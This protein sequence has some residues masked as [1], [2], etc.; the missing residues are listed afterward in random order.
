VSR[1]FLRATTELNC[2]N[3]AITLI[4]PICLVRWRA[5]HGWCPK[6]IPFTRVKTEETERSESE[7]C[8]LARSYPFTQLRQSC[9]G[10]AGDIHGV[11]D[12]PTTSQNKPQKAPR[13]SEKEVCGDSGIPR[14]R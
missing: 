13:V 6:G 5:H 9:S 11:G 4:D 1:E 12:G 10:L 2:R 8:R 3:I 7:G 14:A